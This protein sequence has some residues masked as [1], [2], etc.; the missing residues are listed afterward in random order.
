[1]KTLL[2]L[3]HAKSSWNNANMTDHDRPLNERGK[4]DAP[5]AGRALAAQDVVPE[6]IITSTAERAMSTAE[7]AAA[8]TNDPP[9]LKYERRLYLASPLTILKILQEL[10]NGPQRVMVVGHNP[11]LEELV[12]HLT[13]EPEAMPTAAIAQVDL[14]ITAWSELNETTRGRLS[15]YWQP[16]DKD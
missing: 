11:G 15:W 14:P 13:E 5:R 1:M 12:Y 2:I 4:R 16:K 8:A 6:L 10:G 3:R 7:A 9:E